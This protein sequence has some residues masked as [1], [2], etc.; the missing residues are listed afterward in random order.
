M[1]KSSDF[2]ASPPL[3]VVVTC[4]RETGAIRLHRNTYWAPFLRDFAGQQ[5]VATF[6]PDRLWEGIEVSIIG[7]D[8]GLAPAVERAGFLSV[9]ESRQHE[10]ARRAWLE[11]EERR[12]SVI[13]ETAEAFGMSAAERVK[14]IYPAVKDVGA[15]APAAGTEVAG[16]LP[17]AAEEESLR[18]GVMPEGKGGAE[19]PDLGQQGQLKRDRIDA[20]RDVFGS[21][22]HG[23]SPSGGFRATVRE[24]VDSI[25]AFEDSPAGLA[26]GLA[27]IF[28]LP[29]AL[30]A[31]NEGGVR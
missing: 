29:L 23:G 14:A 11:A 12:L 30:L 17:D 8:L 5:V 22:S 4:D 25:K 28:A 3:R 10:A 27:L 1:S 6:D 24:A 21:C 9:A 19:Q 16:H 2:T 31:L 26:L 18:G 20:G 13:R 7:A 15:V